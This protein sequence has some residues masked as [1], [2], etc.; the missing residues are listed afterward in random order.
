MPDAFPDESG[1][2]ER[3]IA[4]DAEAFG[5]LYRLHMDA[6]YRYIYFRVDNEK[7][8]EDLTERVFLKAWEALDGYEQRGN[9]F[10][11]WLYRIA[12]NV[13]VDHHRRHRPL[14]ST[15]L[16]ERGDWTSDEPSALE[17]I[18]EAEE[19]SALASAIT[20]LPEEYQQII[21]LRFVEGMRHAEVGEIMNKSEGA[22][23]AMQRRALLALHRRLVSLREE[24]GRG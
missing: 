15:P 20:D 4:G 17:Q 5:E 14:F 24:I 8:A 7:D 9:R 11:S 23:R 6:I 21:M 2:T 22:C 16:L 10:G 3:A 12:H 13:V 18:I 1:L 19:A